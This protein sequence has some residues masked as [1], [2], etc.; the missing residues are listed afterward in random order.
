MR[1]CKFINEWLT[2]HGIT[3][4]DGFASVL[5]GYAKEFGR[6]NGMK[7]C[8]VYSLLGCSKQ[9]VSYWELHDDSTQSRHSIFNVIRKAEKLFNLD[10]DEAEALA[11]SGG[12]SLIFEGGDLIKNLNYRGRRCDLYNGAMISERMLRYYKKNTH[13]TSSDRACRI[14]EILCHR[15]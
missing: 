11:N 5:R 15:D 7:L 6:K 10:T 3:L 14:F 13:E 8:D 2:S 9:N 12:L 1:D 4:A